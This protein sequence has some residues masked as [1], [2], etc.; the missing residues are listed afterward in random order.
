MKTDAKRDQLAMFSIQKDTKNLHT[1]FCHTSE[2]ITHT[3]GR[4]MGLQLTGTLKTCEDSALEKQK[5]AILEER[6]FSTS[7]Y[8]QLPLFEVRSISYW[9][10]RT[11]PIMFGVI[12]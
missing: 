7:A 9:S 12:F 10:L 2:A 6:L 5:R 3:S 4:G 8:L 11:I 1:E